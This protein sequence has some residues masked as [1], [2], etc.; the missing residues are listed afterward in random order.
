M[1]S[2]QLADG[3]AIIR[4]ETGRNGLY[5]L[6]RTDGLAGAAWVT[7]ADNIAGTG[8]VVQVADAGGAGKPSAFY[9]I[10]VLN[11]GVQNQLN[12]PEG[13]TN[14]FTVWLTAQPTNN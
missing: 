14:A 1:T 3:D 12:V 5:R 9:R 2:I 10:L 11:P 6:E 8:Q 7:A 4:F 13:G